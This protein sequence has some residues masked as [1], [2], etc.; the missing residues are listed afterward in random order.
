MQWNDAVDGDNET[1]SAPYMPRSV[2]CRDAFDWSGERRPEIAL[3]DSVIYE[4]HVKGSHHAPSAG[5][6]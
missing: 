5:A 4:L 3:V 2:V 1:D 6:P